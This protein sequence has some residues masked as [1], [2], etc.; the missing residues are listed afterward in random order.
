MYRTEYVVTEYTL[1]YS[2]SR[3]ISAS[4]G[5]R[6][7]VTRNENWVSI[8]RNYRLPIL[9]ERVTTAREISGTKFQKTLI[10]RVPSRVAHVDARNRTNVRILNLQ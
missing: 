7:Y 6:K 8:T 10:F 2:R 9:G 1:R 4:I 3:D 5:S